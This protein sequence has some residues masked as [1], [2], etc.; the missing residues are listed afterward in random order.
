MR[1]LAAGLGLLVAAAGI[2]IAL[3]PT[4]LLG[5]CPVLEAKPAAAAA[6]VSTPGAAEV[7]DGGAAPPRGRRWTL[8]PWMRHVW[9]YVAARRAIDSIGAAYDGDGVRLFQRADLARYDGSDPG[10]PLLLAID[11]DV[12]DVTDKGY[13]FYGPGMGYSVFVGRDSSRALALGSLLQAD[14]DAGGDVSDFTDDQR[15]ALQE[16]HDFYRGKYVLYGR[17]V[18]AAAA[19]PPRH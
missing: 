14:I 16:Q 7:H 11:G 1:R 12:F 10:L 5:E 17:L 15:R 6:V 18:D 2:G 3:W 19:A 13:H 8:P 4:D 9:P